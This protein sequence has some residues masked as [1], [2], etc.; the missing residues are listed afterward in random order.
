MERVSEYLD[1]AL[2]P[3]DRERL[4]EHLAGCAACA[5]QVHGLRETLLGLQSLPREPMPAT[6]KERLRQA[7]HDRQSA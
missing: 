2:P 6:M 4:E 5:R 3:G 7:L 1:D